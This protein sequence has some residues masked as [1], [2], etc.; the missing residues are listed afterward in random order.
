M[1]MVLQGKTSYLTAR[2]GV[3]NRSNLVAAKDANPANR[4]KITGRQKTVVH[5]QNGLQG[6]KAK[7]RFSM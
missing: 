7:T 3:L 1:L 5:A 2:A 6:K 4:G